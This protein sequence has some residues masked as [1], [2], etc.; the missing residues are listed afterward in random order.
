MHSRPRTERSSAKCSRA[1]CVGL[2]ARRCDDTDDRKRVN[3]CVLKH[4]SLEGADRPKK[5][6]KNPAH[7]FSDALLILIRINS[8]P[9]ILRS[10]FIH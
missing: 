9:K 3:S 1:L 8:E 4:L 10:C 2:V 6:P 5:W 7:A